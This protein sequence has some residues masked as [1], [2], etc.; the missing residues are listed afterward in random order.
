MFELDPM[1]LVG[2]PMAWVYLFVGVVGGLLVGI[3]PGVG[4]PTAVAVFI[5]VIF[6][7]DPVYAVVFLC[8]LTAVTMTGGALTSIL[9]GVPGESVNAATV[10]DGYPMA[11]RGEAARAIGAALT[12]SA[13]GGVIGAIV[14]VLSIPLM[15]P[16]VLSFGHP[17]LFMLAVTG[18]TFVALIS[19]GSLL[20][21]LIMAS[22]GVLLALVGF[23]PV[24]GVIRYSFG[25]EYLRDG[26]QLIPV[27]IGLFALPE[28]YSLFKDKPDEMDAPAPI[29][30][31]GRS[32]FRGQLQGAV[33][34]FKHWHLVVR[35]SLIGVFLG[36]VPGVGAS[37]STFIAYGHAR[38]FSKNADAFGT[39]A[40]EGVIAPE[41]ANNAKDGG[42][43]VPT[44]AF[45]VPGSSV[46]VVLLA[47][48][49][50]VGLPVGPEL[51]QSGQHIIITIA[52]IIALANVVGTT[53]SFLGAGGIVRLASV[54]PS[55]II[56]WVVLF[57]VIGA[58]TPRLVLSDLLVAILTGAVA[59]VLIKFDYSVVALLLGLVLGAVF[60]VNLE[61]SI[62]YFGWSMFTRPF[63][64]VLVAVVVLVIG[65][66]AWGQRK[67]SVKPK[68]EEHA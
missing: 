56:P 53:A 41:A 43:L 16:L 20:K 58:Y 61:A 24:T 57:V 49:T 39:G 48:F 3:L 37:V 64:L 11:K 68:V 17:E 5:P 38:Q 9:F 45:G 34:T 59:L 31:A 22:L 25:S 2:D 42:G 15:R 32:I 21:G 19:R 23:D 18:L 52:V 60:N 36:M 65:Q 1:A 67:T 14:L 35:G 6:N 55:L 40:V 62:A 50:V 46:M 63:T 54:E 7:M 33:D 29:D 66:A 12:S 10:L 13:V 30:G 27:L 44:L 8:A 4:A 51:L 47:A 28:I 26:V